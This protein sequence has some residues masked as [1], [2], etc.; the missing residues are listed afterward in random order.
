[1][2]DCIVHLHAAV[3]RVAPITGDFNGNLYCLRI[4]GERRRMPNCFYFS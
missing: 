4:Q 2:D 1:M 3:V